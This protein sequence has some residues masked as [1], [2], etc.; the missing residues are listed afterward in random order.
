MDWIIRRVRLSP[1]ELFGVD[2]SALFGIPNRM[3][4][5]TTGGSILIERAA[6]QAQSHSQPAAAKAKMTQKQPAYQDTPKGAPQCDK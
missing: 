2:S 6:I 1:S 4:G 5:G 3:W